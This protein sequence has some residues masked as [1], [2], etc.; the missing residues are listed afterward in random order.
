MGSS[1]RSTRVEILKNFTQTLFLLFIYSF[2]LMIWRYFIRTSLI[3]DQIFAISL[4]S[5]LLFVSLKLKENLN[6]N[7][8]KIPD[9]NITIIS[10]LLFFI[11]GTS[12]LMNVDRSRSIYI[13]K[14]INRC[15]ETP[16]K[17]YTECLISSRTDESEVVFRIREQIARKLVK[18]ENARYELTIGGSAIFVASNQLA[19]IFNLDGYKNA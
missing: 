7:K 13:F 4:V 14:W 17:D 19:H 6:F 15:Q 5:L 1:G 8:L 12:V 11:L 18:E 16:T 2:I 9:F 3:F 10:I